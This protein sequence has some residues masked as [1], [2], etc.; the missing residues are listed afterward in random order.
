VVLALA[1]HCT[2]ITTLILPSATLLTDR[3]VASLARRCTNLKILRLTSCALLTDES[4]LQLTL[5]C[6]DLRIVG[7]QGC[8][9]VSKIALKTLV[10]AC[11]HLCVLY[12]SAT[13]LSRAAAE[14]LSHAR[15]PRAIYIQRCD[16]T[17][18][19]VFSF[20]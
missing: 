13:S 9:Q 11:A 4:V 2:E 14:E 12:V 18:R 7:L 20:E 16:P 6:P 3:S 5:Y 15:S 10:Q 8:A 19:A 17:G 1:V